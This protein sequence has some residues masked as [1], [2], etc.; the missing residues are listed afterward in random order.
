MQQA[1]FNDDDRRYPHFEESPYFEPVNQSGRS[2]RSES[3]YQMQSNHKDQTK[4]LEP[5]IRIADWRPTDFKSQ[6]KSFRNYKI[7]RIDTSQVLPVVED[8]YVQLTDDLT[9]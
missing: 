9:P 5:T 7:N 2:N 1:Q 8:I 3:F 4:K 6:L